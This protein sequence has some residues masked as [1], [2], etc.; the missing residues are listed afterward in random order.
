MPVAA[1]ALFKAPES[2]SNNSFVIVIDIDIDV[3]CVF[4][5]KKVRRFSDGQETCE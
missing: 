1:V 3:M 4:V 5:C 2:E